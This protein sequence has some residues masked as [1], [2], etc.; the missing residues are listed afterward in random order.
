MARLL[1]ARWL[2]MQ[3]QRGS[4][5]FPFSRCSFA[6]Y[7]VRSHLGIL[8]NIYACIYRGPSPR[9]PRN[10]NSRRLEIIRDASK[11]W[12]AIARAAPTGIA[13]ISEGLHFSSVYCVLLLITERVLQFLVGLSL[14][15]L[16]FVS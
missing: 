2:G 5:T 12:F 11:G 13:R 15:V 14:A 3:P 16:E 8:S 6:N 1:S 7:S 9:R 4:A 10:S